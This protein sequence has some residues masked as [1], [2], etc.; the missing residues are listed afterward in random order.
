M[1]ETSIQDDNE[2]PFDAVTFER[3]VQRASLD[4]QRIVVQ[5]A[6]R[7]PALRN[8]KRRGL[9]VPLTWRALFDIDEQAFADLGFQGRHPAT[10]REGFVRLAGSR[11]VDADHDMPVDWQRDE[12]PVPAVYAIVRALVQDSPVET[13]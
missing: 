2:S 4:L 7:H 6:K 5:L 11:V 8:D 9:H 10:V 12:D 1:Y 3:A 13:G